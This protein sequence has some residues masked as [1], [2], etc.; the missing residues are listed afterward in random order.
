[1]R[2]SKLETQKL[3][4]VQFKNGYMVLGGAGDAGLVDLC[5]RELQRDFRSHEYPWTGIES[6]LMH[7]AKSIFENHIQVYAGF[8]ED[9]IPELSM[10]VAVWMDQ[11]CRLYRWE[12]NYVVP[13]PLFTHDAIGLGVLQATS[14]LKE[15]EFVTDCEHMLFYAIR[16]MQQVKRLVPGCGGKTEI[17]CMVNEGKP[18]KYLPDVI[19]PI[20]SLADSLDWN[21]IKTL[22]YTITASPMTIDAP[23]FNAVFEQFEQLRKLYRGLRNWKDEE[24]KKQPSSLAA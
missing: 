4:E 3:Y 10:L 20:E 19:S 17:I 15:H 6:R 5:I 14:L 2:V 11:Q 7:H 9:M 13:V 1:M 16:L 21:V 18:K 24:Y 8:S 23:E 12:K 22:F